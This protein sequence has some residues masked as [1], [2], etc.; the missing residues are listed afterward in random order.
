V[1]SH[2]VLRQN[3]Q[4]VKRLTES[5]ADVNSCTGGEFSASALHMAAV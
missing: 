5:G 1:K 4:A 2:A 3:F